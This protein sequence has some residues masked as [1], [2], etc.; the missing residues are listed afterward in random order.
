MYIK[1]AESEQIVEK[2]NQVITFY[3]RGLYEN[4]TFFALDLQARMHKF[5]PR[6]YIYCKEARKQESH[7]IP[8]GRRVTRYS[9]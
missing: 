2:Q 9:F 3:R 5:S 1:R 6:F 7:D 8:S 4:A